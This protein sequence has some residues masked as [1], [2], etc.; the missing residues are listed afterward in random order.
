MKC[1]N[2]IIGNYRANENVRNEFHH[3][4][5]KVFPGISFKEWYSKGFWTE[6]YI[7]P[8][9]LSY[10]YDKILKEDTGLFILG[11]M[12]V[13]NNPFRFPETAVT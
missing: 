7:P 12:E 1:N 8:D 2:K 10:N 4:I 6:N 9:Q 5:S 13:G 3:F 11:D